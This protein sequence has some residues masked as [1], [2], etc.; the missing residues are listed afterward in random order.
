[1]TDL[2]AEF[3]AL[4]NYRPTHKVRFVTAASLFD[5]HDAAINIMRRILQGMGA[6]VIHLGHNRSVDEVVTAALQEDVQGIAVSSYQGGHVEYFKYMVDLLRQRGGEHIQVFGGGGGVIVPAEI[7]ELHE[8]GVT[9]IYSPEDGQRMGLQGMIGEMVMRCDRDLSPHAPTDAG[10]IEGHDYSH[11]RALAQLIT[12]I[13]N[14]AADE[15]LVARVRERAGARTVP[16]VGITGTGGAGKSSLTDELIRRLRLDQDDRLHVAVIS[17]DPSRRKSGGALLGDRIRMNAIS[18]WQQGPRVFMRSLATRDF[19]SEISA[20]LPDVIAACKAAGFDLV[21]VE[22][23]G[24]GQGDAAIVPLVDV[25][26]YVMTPEFGAASQ[27]E[28]IDMLDFAEF[29]AINK[30]DRKGAAD[31]LR[32]VAKQVQRNREAWTR[33]PEEMPVFGTMAAR[34]NDDGVTALYQALRARLQELGLPVQAGRLPEVGGRHSTNQTPIVPGARVRYLAEISDTVRGYKKRAREQARLAR[35]IQQLQ[36]AARMLKVDKPER[37][38]AAEAALDLAGKRKARMDRD[39]LHLLQQWPDMQR[40]YAGDEYV[41]KIRDKEIRTALTTKSLSG[42]TIRK[43]ALPAYEDHGEILK[44]LMLDNVPGSFPYTAGTFAFK[45]ENE[46][47]TRMFAGEGDAFRTNRRFKLLS[48]GMPAK[49]LSTAFDSVTLYGNDPAERPDIYGK[50]GNSGVSIATLEDMEVLYSGFDLCS[51]STSVSMTINGPAPTILA[52]FMNTAIDQ[53]LEKF[54][55]DNGREPTATEAAKVREWVLANVR[56]TVQADILKEDQGQNTCIFSTEFSLKVMGDIAQYFVHHNVRNFYSVSISGYHIAEAGANPISQLAFTLSNGFTLVEA[57]LARGMHIDD[58]APNLSFFFSNGMDPEYTV[59]GRVARRIWAVAMK[60]K[61]GANE[62]SQKLKYHIQTSGRSLHAQEIQFNDIRTTLQALIAIYDN[63]NSLHTNAFDEAITTPTE[64]SVRRA[65]AI[66]LIINREWGLAKNENPNQG[67]FIMEELTELV[68]E[69]VL[70]EFERIAERGGVLGAME[71]G[72]QR[73]KIQDES[74]H[75]EMLK[76]TGELPIVGVNTFRNPHGDTVLE[77]LELARSTEDEKLGQLRRLQDFQ[78]RNATA[79]P[80]MLQRLQQ[81]VIDNGN[82][83]EVLMDAV[84]VCSL[85]QI[86]N[87]LFEVG[88]QYRR[89][90]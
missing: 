33:R 77:K 55:T 73:G 49:R 81:A 40:A 62:R 90:M 25:P 78:S 9:R 72:Y 79:A 39:A 1:M 28:K 14:G 4:A 37:A 5:G 44:W 24:I 75:Y 3:K 31:A 69:A 36:E 27:L 74:M 17:I 51:P 58:F 21:V 67:A 7:R 83:F 16:V 18:P 13:E 70:A 34:F 46:D 41:V 11:W 63:C 32:D 19:G 2:S 6:E 52:M 30:F 65:M 89:N 56:G 87:A 85:G 8:Y 20:A 86:T 22:T 12:A 10:A 71:T 50:V 59:M 47:P 84:R 88:G 29:V 64:D 23:S 76:H 48:E 54:R 82:V 61:Y 43:V 57:Y 53:Q 26:L 35:E 45:R 66:Q 15:A 80:A 68:E 38:P 42:T 60:D